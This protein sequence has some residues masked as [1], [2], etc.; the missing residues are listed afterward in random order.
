MIGK[1]NTIEKIVILLEMQ[2][3]KVSNQR[4]QELQEMNMYGLAWELKLAKAGI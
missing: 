2:G 4:L 3:V 1:I